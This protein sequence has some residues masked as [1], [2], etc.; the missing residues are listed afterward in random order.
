MTDT[1]DTDSG[2]TAAR[3]RVTP[4]SANAFHLLVEAVEAVKTVLDDIPPPTKEQ[5]LETLSAAITAD[6][7]GSAE[8]LKKLTKAVQELE[9]LIGTCK[10]SKDVEEAK[11][12][13]KLAVDELRRLK[14]SAISWGWRLASGASVVVVNAVGLWWIGLPLVVASTNWPQVT[15]TLVLSFLWV[16]SC[17]GALWLTFRRGAGD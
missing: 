11:K 12:R 1:R 13:E 16:V 6:R 2:A 15:G 17:L 10:T 14:G 4:N 8:E 3:A 7:E 5:V 9:S